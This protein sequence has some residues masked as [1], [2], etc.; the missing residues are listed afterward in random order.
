MGEKEVTMMSRLSPGRAFSIKMT[1]FEPR[2]GR[3]CKEGL[4]ERDVG[5]GRDKV[6]G[7]PVTRFA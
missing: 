4:L 1:H 5:Q 3:L 6:L 7:D 2:L